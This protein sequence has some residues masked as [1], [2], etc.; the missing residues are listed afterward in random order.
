MSEHMNF[1]NGGG[2]APQDSTAAAV[3][4]ALQQ[5]KASNKRKRDSSDLGGDPKHLGAKRASSSNALNGN[6]H[7]A[8]D[9]SRV[10]Y[11]DGM[12]DPSASQD[13]NALTQQLARHVANAN[14]N[15]GLPDNSNSNSA[16]GL[17]MMPQLT[18]PQPT[19]LSFVSTGSGPDA[20][21]QLDASFDL[22]DNG[23]NHNLQGSPYGMGGFQGTSS[24]VQNARESSNGG[25][26]K[27]AVGS[28][29]WHKVRRDNHKEGE[30]VER[31]HVDHELTLE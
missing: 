8:N 30:Q 16:S 6:G 10:L 26:T 23:Q 4:H 20:D 9:L 18:V 1:E 13:F 31:D 28:D 17:G 3:D 27:P 14:A 7:D 25:G 11:A 24:Q 2:P 19:E 12:R 15:H 22:V 5:L 29:E 21:R